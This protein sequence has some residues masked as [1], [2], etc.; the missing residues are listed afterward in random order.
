[1]ELLDANFQEKIK[2]GEIKRHRLVKK[3]VSK[4]KSAKKFQFK[5]FKVKRVYIPPPEKYFRPSQTTNIQCAR[6]GDLPPP[7]WLNRNH[8]EFSK[9]LSFIFRSFILL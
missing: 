1:M 9:K 6:V 2:S 8:F 7:S 4:E 5:N 3:K